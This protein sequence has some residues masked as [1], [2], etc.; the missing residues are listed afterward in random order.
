MSCV[1]S[2]LI[3][4]LCVGCTNALDGDTTT[5]GPN[6]T[7]SAVQEDGRAAVTD[8]HVDGARAA[9]AG[10]SAVADASVA[11]PDATVDARVIEPP[12]DCASITGLKATASANDGNVPTNAIDGSNSTRWSAK[13]AGQ[14]IRFELPNGQPVSG[15][16]LAWYRGDERRTAFRIETSVDGKAYREVFRGWSRSGDAELSRYGFAASDAKF[17]RVVCQGNTVNSWC[18]LSEA[19]V[20]TTGCGAT[21]DRAPKD[22]FGI[23]RLYAAPSSA[24][25]WDSQ[26]WKSGSSRLLDSSGEKDPYDRT[27]WSRFRGSGSMYVNPQT[28]YMRLR[29]NQPRIYID[30]LSSHR[31]VNTETTVYYQRKN[32]DAIAYA[33]GIIGARSSSGGHGTAP[34]TANTYYSMLRHDGAFDFAKELHHP[35]AAKKTIVK[36]VWNGGALP[37]QKWIGLKYVIYTLAGEVVLETYRDLT[38]GKDGGDWQLLGRYVDR[39]GWHAKESCSYP[40]DLVVT[41][42]GGIVFIRN[43]GVQDALYK[44]MSVQEL[45]PQ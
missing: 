19:Q 41:E 23:K 7:D 32:D 37:K 13:G 39:G 15:L 8:A 12:S 18:S 24:K 36:N 22:A 17:V 27:G 4:T 2:V 29:G 40:S 3:L 10:D 43:T 35:N 21:S 44:W 5:D 16:M 33:G 34:C 30:A 38:G 42:G 6:F 9:D 20:L 11:P 31:W 1:R 26:H 14:S 28:G 25:K 45:P